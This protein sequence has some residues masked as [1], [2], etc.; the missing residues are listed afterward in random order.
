VHQ[1]IGCWINDRLFLVKFKDKVFLLLLS[2]TFF[3][4]ISFLSFDD[5]QG[6]LKLI[7]ERKVS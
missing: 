3:F 5:G 1:G 2:Q 4:F 7:K 6:V